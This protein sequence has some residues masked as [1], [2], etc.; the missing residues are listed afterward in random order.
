MSVP[1][2]TVDEPRDGQAMRNRTGRDVVDRAG[3]ADLADADES[4][5]GGRPAGAPGGDQP[6]GEGPG[7]QQLDKGPGRTS[8]GVSREAREEHGG[9]HPLQPKVPYWLSQVPYLLV[10]SALGAGTVVVAAA[11]FKRGPAIIAGALLLAAAFRLFLPRDWIGMLAVRRRWVDL[12]T[13]VSLAVLLI[14]LAWVAPQLS[15]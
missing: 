14:V 13:L 3:Q 12:L 7:G 2:K 6:G 1:G 5:P 9:E 11:Y 15:P 4:A 8:E 10:L